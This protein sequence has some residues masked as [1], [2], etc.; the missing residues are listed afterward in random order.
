MP[1][2][3]ST[4]VFTSPLSVL[5]DSADQLE[6]GQHS[7]SLGSV[8]V[9]RSQCSQTDCN[10]SHCFGGQE[11]DHDSCTGQPRQQACKL[12]Q[13][14]IQVSFFGCEFLF[15]DLPLALQIAAA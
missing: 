4:V 5:S 15:V 13:N 3:P 6:V 7:N 1:I 10:E 12:D 2:N 9:P 8:K 11:L 14:K